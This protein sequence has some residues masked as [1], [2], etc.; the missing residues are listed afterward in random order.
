MC[1]P[2]CS[3]GLI[4]V[5]AG[6]LNWGNYSTGTAS[7]DAGICERISYHHFLSQ[8]PTFTSIVENNPALTSLFSGGD[9]RGLMR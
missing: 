8:M 1:L 4:Q 5:T 9:H 6:V 7:C 2:R 3:R